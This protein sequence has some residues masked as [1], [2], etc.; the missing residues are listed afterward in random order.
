M[1]HFK[2]LFQNFSQ[3]LFFII[4][5]LFVKYSSGLLVFLLVLS[6]CQSIPVKSSKDLSLKVSFSQNNV[7]V[8]ALV[9]I[10]GERLRADILRPFLGPFAYLYIKGEEVALLFPTEKKYYRGEFKS[11]MFLPAMENL[12]LKW[13]VAILKGELL[14]E[15]SCISRKQETYCKTGGVQIFLKKQDSKRTVAVLQTGNE[16]IKIRIRRLSRKLL[17]EEVFTYNLKGY[18]LLANLKVLNFQGF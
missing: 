17:T 2:N 11:G 15:K 12:P 7:S 14:K 5:A 18:Q 9:F 4:Q 16:K 1:V 13:F 6:G 3:P 10:K 8:G